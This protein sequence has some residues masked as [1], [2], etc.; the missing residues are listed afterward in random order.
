MIDFEIE[1]TCFNKSVTI[2]AILIAKRKH[3][4]TS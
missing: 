2:T 1:I 4:K 3:V